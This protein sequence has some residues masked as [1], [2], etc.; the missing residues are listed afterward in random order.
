MFCF[1]LFGVLLS[2][3][4]I[5]VHLGLVV[6]VV[7]QGAVDLPETSDEDTGGGFAGRPSRDQYDP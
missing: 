2:S 7:S 3:L 6:V 4:D 5:G 1:H